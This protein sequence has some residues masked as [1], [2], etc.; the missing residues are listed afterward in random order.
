MAANVRQATCY[1]Q[2]QLVISS[3]IAYL[4]EA[5]SVLI[6]TGPPIAAQILREKV[7]PTN[8]AR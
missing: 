7:K 6:L 4:L 3:D 1:V 5:A 2:Q 8:A